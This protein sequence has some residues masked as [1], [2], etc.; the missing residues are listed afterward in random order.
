MSVQWSCR[1][2]E[3]QLSVTPGKGDRLMCYCK[4]CQAFAHYLDAAEILDDAGGSDIYS[5]VPSRIEVVRGAENLTCLRQTDKGAVRWYTSCCNTPMANTLPSG[6]VPF[7]SLILNE[8]VDAGALG[9][10]SM[11][12]NSAGA[13][14]PIAQSGKGALSAG[15]GMLGRALTERLAGRT[16]SPL[17]GPDR[18][19]SVTPMRVRTGPDA[20]A[21]GA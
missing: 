1:C 9:P 10:I 19:P 21:P 4:Y 13:T 6:G 8:G 11:V 3:T 15:L 2:G 14:G 17:F 7:F 18:K 16:A 12:V 5:T 20:P